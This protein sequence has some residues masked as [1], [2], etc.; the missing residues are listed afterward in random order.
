MQNMVDAL[1]VAVSGALVFFMQPGFQMVESGLT[2]EKN[3][4]NVAIKNLTDIGI[5]LF[6]YWLIGF[7]LMFGKSA[8]GILG[9]TNFIPG[10]MGNVDFT[11]TAYYIPRYSAQATIT[12][13][14]P[15][16]DIDCTN[17]QY[18]DNAIAGV[19][20]EVIDL[21]KGN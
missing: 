8:G 1:W 15:Q 17:K 19:T 12:T 20:V 3:S 9:F 14:T 18:V 21:S 10:A 5:S 2:R 16:K 11:A 7:A 4:I 6:I 13:Q